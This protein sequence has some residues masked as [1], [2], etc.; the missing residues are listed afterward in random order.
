MII[1]V[2]NLG[3]LLTLKLAAG[4]LTLHFRISTNKEKQAGG[5]KS[6]WKG[7]DGVVFV[8]GNDEYMKRKLIDQK[9]TSNF[10]LY[11]RCFSVFCHVSNIWIISTVRDTEHGKTHIRACAEVEGLGKLIPFQSLFLTCALAV[12]VS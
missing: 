12:T 10:S 8:R 4:S 9:M 7:M 2:V 3:K 5:E 11:Y 1:S 6:G